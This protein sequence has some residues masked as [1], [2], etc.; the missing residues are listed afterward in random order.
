LWNLESENLHEWL[1]MHSRDA[2]R[3]ALT[4]AIAGE[5]AKASAR[6]AQAE[7]LVQQLEE[8]ICSEGGCAVC[9]TIA[10][11]RALLLGAPDGR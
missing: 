3:A 10:V 2:V 8:H 1:V 4:R 5:R 7:M 9:D 6:E 11:L